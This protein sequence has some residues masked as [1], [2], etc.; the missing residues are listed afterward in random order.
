MEEKTKQEIRRLYRSDEDR[1]IA[2]IC[3]GLGDYFGIDPVLIRL[4]WIIFA[5]TGGM[6]IVMY[7]LFWIFIPRENPY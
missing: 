7:L 3:G 4:V 5:L 2:G 1:V 6:G